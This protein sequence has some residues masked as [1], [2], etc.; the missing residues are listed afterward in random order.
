MIDNLFTHQ[1]PFKADSGNRLLLDL[2]LIISNSHNPN[3]NDLGS[4]PQ[5]KLGNKEC[6]APPEPLL[7]YLTNQFFLLPSGI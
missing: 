6:T 1:K 4:V 3:Q 5:G 7:F 2:C